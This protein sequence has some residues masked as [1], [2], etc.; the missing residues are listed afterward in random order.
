MTYGRALE[1]AEHVLGLYAETGPD[2]GG[3]YPYATLQEAIK[4]LHALAESGVVRDD[5]E[6]GE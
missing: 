6:E 3:I 5:W 1:I 2:V 4:T